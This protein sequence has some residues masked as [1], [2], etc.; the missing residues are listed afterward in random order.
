MVPSLRVLTDASGAFELNVPQSGRY[1]LRAMRIGYE[2][3]EEVEVDVG[4]SA[5]AGVTL[6]LSARAV[7]LASIRVSARDECRVAPDSG[8]MV[9]R[10]WQEARKALVGAQLNEGS[11][12]QVDW[13]VYDRSLDLSGQVVRD[14]EVTL[15]SARTARAFRSAPAR[16]LA[17]RGY[18]VADGDALEYFAP[19]AEVL[20]SEEFAGGHCLRLRPGIAGQEGL[21]GVEFHPAQDRRDV[22]DI[23]GTLWLDRSSAELRSLDFRYTNLPSEAARVRPGGQVEYVRLV[24]GGWIVSRWSIRMPMVDIDSVWAGDLNRRTYRSSVRTTLKASGVRVAGG[25]VSRVARGDSVIFEH[26]IGG[27]EVRVLGNAGQAAGGTMVTLDGTNA[28]ATSDSSGVARFGTLLPGRYVA[29]ATSPLM[30]T[31]GVS[32]VLVDVEVKESG[33]S[34]ASVRLPDPARYGT[35]ICGRDLG[36]AE[37]VVRGVTRD[38]SGRPAAFVAVTASWIAPG[39]VNARAGAGFSA[40]R[41]ALGT[42]SDS[43]GRWR[44]CGVR[45][46]T[47]VALWAA[48]ER[49][50]AHAGTEFPEGVAVE[51]VDLVLAPSSRAA[52]GVRRDGTATLEVIVTATDHRPVSNARVRVEPSSGRVVEARTDAS[53]RAL[54]PQLRAGPHGLDVRGVGFAPGKLVLA[55]GEGRNT[56]PIILDAVRSPALDTVRVVAGR[57]VSSRLD[58]F[59][60]RRARG[61]ASASIGAEEIARRNPAHAW[62][63]LATVPSVRTLEGPG[64]IGL[65]SSRVSI[66]NLIDPSIRH[67]WFRVAVDGVLLPGEPPNLAELPPPGDIHGI[68]VF[69][70]PAKIPL[71]YAGAGREKWCGLLVVWTK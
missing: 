25:L 12:L 71:E 11:L 29:M 67:C 17:E 49:G 16:Q 61:E 35:A 4:S 50:S 64:G 55:V 53:G 70:G 28:R 15:R 26:A 3:S 36:P 45:R 33:M 51:S 62:Q 22:R 59:E 39:S 6:V 20:L 57:P 40:T 5:T 34:T 48:D 10:V 8:L 60:S 18:V 42:F 9:A 14:Q 23:E 30:D 56:A 37:G 52:N 38:G 21:I 63:L 1:F 66:T 43:L 19:D 24:P 68:E 65:Y 47:P 58:A 32:A 2:P 44:I 7:N 13:M 27:L 41:R 54:F 69:A 31:L 46:G